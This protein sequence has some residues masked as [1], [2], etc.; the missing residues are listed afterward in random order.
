[1]IFSDPTQPSI[2]AAGKRSDGKKH[3]QKTPT[4]APPVD[5]KK[6]PWEALDVAF[7]AEATGLCQ[8]V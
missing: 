7:Q 4:E 8:R 3:R 1:M 5:L 2:P 6:T